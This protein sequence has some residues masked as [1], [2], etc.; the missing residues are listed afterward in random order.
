M[1]YK[2]FILDYDK[3][4]T[5]EIIEEKINDLAESYDIFSVQYLPKVTNS[6]ESITS[7]EVVTA[8]TK[9]SWVIV[10]TEKE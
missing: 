5:T 2:V 8:V 3:Y 9:S 10:V 4:H 6:I 1:K 7:T